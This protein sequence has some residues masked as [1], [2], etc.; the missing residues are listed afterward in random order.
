MALAP[1]VKAFVQ[2]AVR[3]SEDRLTRVDREW[4]RLRPHRTIVTEVIQAGPGELTEQARE[5]R[6]FVI[7][8]AR[9]AAVE[10]PEERLIPENLAEAILPA[11][12]ALLA[13]TLLQNSGDL[14][15]IQAFTA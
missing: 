5:L 15:K 9:K 2:R 3:L 6:D 13:Q 12:R 11:A 4:D 14:R 10:H 8:E 7:A 1:D